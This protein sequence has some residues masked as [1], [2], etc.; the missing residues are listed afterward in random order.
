[1]WSSRGS[2]PIARLYW[3]YVLLSS[4][5][6]SGLLLAA[7]LR[8]GSPPA[9]P[10]PSPLPGQERSLSEE[11]AELVRT[12]PQARP[13]LERLLIMLD[14]AL[15]MLKTPLPDLL[16]K[17]ELSATIIGRQDQRLQ[18]QQIQLARLQAALTASKVSLTSSEAA[19]RQ[20]RGELIARIQAEQGLR[21][22]AERSRDIA[23]GI[24]AGQAVG[25]VAQ[26]L[27]LIFGK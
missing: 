8:A 4:L 15:A 22:E 16:T 3:R 19:W 9:S 24:N 17:L 11:V 7:G 12:C 21:V 6:L 10:L 5:L 1:M 18:E 14:S 26:A 27:A 20:E 2:K 13:L 23:W 25:N